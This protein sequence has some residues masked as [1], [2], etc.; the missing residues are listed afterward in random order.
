MPS[1]LYFLGYRN[2]EK[3]GGTHNDRRFNEDHSFDKGECDIFCDT[4]T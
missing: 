3:L 4:T 2:F 1:T